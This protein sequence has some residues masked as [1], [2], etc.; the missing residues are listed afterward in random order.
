[1][2]VRQNVALRI[3]ELTG[4]VAS[5]LALLLTNK[6]TTEPIVSAATALPSHGVTMLLAGTL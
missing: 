2:I 5:P 1:M 6:V 4:P 3:E